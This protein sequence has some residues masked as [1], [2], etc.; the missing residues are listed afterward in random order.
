MVRNF[1][2][3]CD[4]KGISAIVIEKEHPLFLGWKKKKMPE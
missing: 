2:W 3:C 1:E 4:S